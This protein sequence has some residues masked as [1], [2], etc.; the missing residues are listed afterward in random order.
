MSPA[1]DFVVVIPARFGS[2]RFPGKALATLAGRPVLEHVWRQCRASGAQETLVATDDARI[3]EAARGFGAE[4]VMTGA[5]H[6]SGTERV[7]EVATQRGWSRD[8]VVINCQGDAPLIPP[9]CIDQV[10]GLLAQHA[11]AGMAT[12]CTPIHERVDFDSSHVVKVV[13]DAQGRALYF[14][15]A[16]IPAAGHGGSGDPPSAYRHV[17][18]YGYRCG[19]LKSLAAAPPCALELAE[20]LE[21]LRALWLGVEIRVGV[22]AQALGPDID[23][24]EQLVQAERLLTTAGAAR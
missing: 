1:A 3:A 7:A 2:T 8:R 13:M 12:L 5:Q 17:G 19:V 15:R 18:L 14:S 11:S 24:P 10:A 6:R 20:N 16:P 9:A 22:T 4:V 21:Q 23:T